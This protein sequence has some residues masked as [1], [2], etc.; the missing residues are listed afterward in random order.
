[1]IEQEYCQ[2]K[3][4]ATKHETLKQQQKKTTRY[5][6]TRRV[7][8]ASIY[9]NAPRGHLSSHLLYILYTTPKVHSKVRRPL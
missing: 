6:L 8:A 4:Q 5:L 7:L 2:T 9:L 3:Q 1:M